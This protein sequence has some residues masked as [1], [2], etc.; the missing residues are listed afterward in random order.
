MGKKVLGSLFLG[1]LVSLLTLY[2]YSSSSTAAS[3]LELDD[4]PDFNFR[5]LPLLKDHRDKQD[6]P[7]VVGVRGDDNRCDA[8]FTS[9]HA[10]VTACSSNHF[11]SL[12]WFLLYAAVHARCETLIL[13]SLQLNGRQ[14]RSLA[15]FSPP[16]LIVRHFDFAQF[17]AYFNISKSAGEYAWKP[18]IVS[19]VLEEF[20]FVVWLDS[21]SY[22]QAPL[23]SLYS[24][25]ALQG[26]YSANSGGLVEK[27]T[28]PGTLAHFGVNQTDS[29]IL[30]SKPCHA[31][32]LGF[33]R[34]QTLENLVTPWKA[35]ALNSDC[36]APKG[37]NRTNH[38]QDQAA[39]TLLVLLSKHRFKCQSV[40]GVRQVVSPH[41]DS[42]KKVPPFLLKDV[43]RT[44]VPITLRALHGHNCEVAAIFGSKPGCKQDDPP[45]AIDLLALLPTLSFNPEVQTR[46]S[47]FGPDV[48]RLEIPLGY[49]L[50]HAVQHIALDTISHSDHEDW[51]VAGKRT[52][53]LYLEDILLADEEE[54]WRRLV[55]GMANTTTALVIVVTK[56]QQ[57]DDFDAMTIKQE[58]ELKRILLTA[59]KGPWEVLSVSATAHLPSIDKETDWLVMAIATR[60]GGLALK[61]KGIDNLEILAPALPV[62]TTKKSLD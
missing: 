35:C 50:G 42:F 37:S 9:S 47:L 27:W 15:L 49:A 34:N 13:Y 43:L 2:R 25:L 31:A 58:Q 28:H 22:L 10:I 61:F 39:L 26:F 45:A 33:S 53:L 12:R 11:L 8:N 40:D 14:L 62:A 7:K 60:D 17:P 56:A 52:T 29:E 41:E 19:E 30:E 24:H 21:G 46:L 20:E 18:V 36:I 54:I 44:E 5:E 1:A 38:R 59:E 3:L 51:L 48:R 23:T 32:F 55:S 57:S 4:I 16:K 6:G